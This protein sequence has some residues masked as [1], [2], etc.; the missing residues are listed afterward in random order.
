MGRQADGSELVGEKCEEERS[1]GY[2]Y[3]WNQGMPLVD[4][5]LYSNDEKT[6]LQHYPGML[7]EENRKQVVE[8]SIE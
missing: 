3:G 6:S 8:E 7:F 4:S 5:L 2:K 1:W